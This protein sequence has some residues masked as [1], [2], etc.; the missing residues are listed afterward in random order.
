MY[1]GAGHDIFILN[2]DNLTKLARNTGND[3]QN[4]ARIDGG[5]GIDTVQLDGASVA[6]DLGSLRENVIEDIERIDLTGS[7]NNTLRLRLTDVLN[8][9]DNNVWNAAN[10]DGVSGEALGVTE[11]RRQLRVDG[12][13]GDQVIVS[14][15]A[16][17]TRATNNMVADGN[18]YGV[19]NHATSLA[20][21]LID[22]RVVVA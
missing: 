3:S 12:N 2:A 6:F 14:D 11:A 15:L 5:T 17:W 4:V 8:F 16:N 20:Q 19:W 10:T 13:S 1:G 21:I 7:G 9:G 22:T 18:T